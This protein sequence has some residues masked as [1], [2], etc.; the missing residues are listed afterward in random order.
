[1]TIRLMADELTWVRLP[2]R[3]LPFSKG[4]V[5]LSVWSVQQVHTAKKTGI[6]SLFVWACIGFDM[7]IFENKDYPQMCVKHLF[8]LNAEENTALAA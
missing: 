4:K 6:N 7:R 1:M 5:L 3:R 8:K 2:Y